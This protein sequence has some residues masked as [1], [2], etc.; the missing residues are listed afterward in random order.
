[1]YFGGEAMCLTKGKTSGVFLQEPTKQLF[2]FSSKVANCP[3][4][5]EP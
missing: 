3:D 1:M 2:M 4:F 5:I